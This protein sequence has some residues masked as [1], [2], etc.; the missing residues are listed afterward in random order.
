VGGAGGF[1]A[2]LPGVAS[3]PEGLRSHQTSSPGKPPQAA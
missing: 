2:L 1:A 3:K